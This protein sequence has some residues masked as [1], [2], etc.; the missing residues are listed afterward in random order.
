MGRQMTWELKFWMPRENRLNAQR[1]LAIENLFPD[2]ENSDD[3]RIGIAFS[4]LVATS[5][6]Q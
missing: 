6:I 1:L 4:K 3:S 2:S 5:L